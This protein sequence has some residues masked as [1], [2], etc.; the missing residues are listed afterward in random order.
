MKKTT[1]IILSL[2]LLISVFTGCTKKEAEKLSSDINSDIQAV[3]TLVKVAGLKGPTGIGMVNMMEKSDE[4]KLLNRYE[5]T[6]VAAPDEIVGKVSSG[7]IDIAAVPTNLAATLYEKTNKGVQM[8]A[9]NTMGMMYILQK[10]ASITKVSDLKGKTV[11]LH[12]KGSTPEFV[13]RHILTKN[14]LDPD[15]DVTIKFL[16][17]HSE[18][19]TQALAGQADIVLVPEPFVT[20][21]TTQNAAFSPVIDLSKEWENLD[22]GDF[23]MGCIIARSEFVSQHKSAVDTFLNEYKT[24]VE[25]ATSDVEKTAAL[26]EKYGVIAK[27][28]VAKKAI[29]NC[30]IVFI[31]GDEMITKTKPYYQILFDADPKSVGGAIPDDAFYYKK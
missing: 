6:L 18:V 16:D 21:I 26:C 20:Q 10:D 25:A 23:S 22:A 12:G 19:A 7:Q 14:N 17:E 8:L 13:L 24:S 29:P 11:T 2:I 5:F 4:E 9:L 31:D 3:K 30:K 1:A 15:K 28:E 27:A